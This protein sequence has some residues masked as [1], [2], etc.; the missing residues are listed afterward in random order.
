MHLYLRVRIRI[1]S[2]NTSESKSKLFRV[3]VSRF[4]PDSLDV[5]S[6]AV[7]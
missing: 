4:S 2:I 6:F 5:R 1:S 3:D 7:R